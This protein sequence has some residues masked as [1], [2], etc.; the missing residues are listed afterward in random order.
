MILVA[1]S[2]IN[3]QNRSGSAPVK[4]Y[5]QLEH[6]RTKALFIEVAVIGP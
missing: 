1:N 4:K 6:L 3:S 5:S 2:E